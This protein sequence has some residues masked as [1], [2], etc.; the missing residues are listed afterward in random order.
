MGHRNERQ[1]YNQ[2]NT[3]SV[4]PQRVSVAMAYV[5]FQTDCEVYTCEKGLRQGT[6]FPVLDK[7]FTMGCAGC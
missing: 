1:T 7:P 3:V 4:F 2:N 5:P 6:M